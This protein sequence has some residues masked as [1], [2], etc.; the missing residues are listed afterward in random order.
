MTTKRRKEHT[1]S[2]MLISMLDTDLVMTHPFEM[3]ICMALKAG[4]KPAYESHHI[5]ESE[6]FCRAATLPEEYIPEIEEK[7]K[8]LNIKWSD[9]KV[10]D[11]TCKPHPLPSNPLVAVSLLS[12]MRS[13]SCFVMSSCSAKRQN[14]C[15]DGSRTL[16][17]WDAAILE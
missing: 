16:S 6:H 1:K 13:S 11:N 3:L 7:L 15:T 10:T 9:F 5:V 2:P 4:S 8:P 12:N 17:P 14:L